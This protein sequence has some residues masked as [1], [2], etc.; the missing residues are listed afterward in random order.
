MGN[1]NVTSRPNDRKSLIPTALCGYNK[2][3]CRYPNLNMVK[4][5]V[6]HIYWEQGRRPGIGSREVIQ[7]TL[8]G[9]SREDSVQ[10]NQQG[11]KDWSESWQKRKENNKRQTNRI[12]SIF[13]Q[14]YLYYKIK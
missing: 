10:Y 6:K 13:D 1:Y 3:T 8:P 12:K 2:I 14:V 9:N 4:R 7:W 5:K 11:N